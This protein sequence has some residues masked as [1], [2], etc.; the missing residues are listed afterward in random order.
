MTKLTLLQRAKARRPRRTKTN[1]KRTREELDLALA[2]V[3][4]DISL[5]QVVVVLK[6]KYNASA[7]GWLAVTLRE[8]VRQKYLGVYGRVETR[9]KDVCKDIGFDKVDMP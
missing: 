5:A 6:G 4:E 3:H 7:L 1:R 9:K 2:W 8:T